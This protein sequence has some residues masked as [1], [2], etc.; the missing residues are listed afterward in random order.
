MKKSHKMK[1]A[2]KAIEITQRRRSRGHF[3]RALAPAYKNYYFFYYKVQRNY[4]DRERVYICTV[5]RKK[6][7]A[8]C[9]FP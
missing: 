7:R 9:K 2:N 6:A 1:L 5:G 3:V 8:T 4:E